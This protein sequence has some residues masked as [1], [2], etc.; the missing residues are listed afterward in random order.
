MYF[1]QFIS[2][3]ILKSNVEKSNNEKKTDL[4]HSYCFC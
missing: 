1:N 3:M 4:K 2:K